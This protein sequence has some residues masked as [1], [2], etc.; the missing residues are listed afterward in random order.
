M[1]QSGVSELSHLD[2]VERSRVRGDPLF[3]FRRNARNTTKAARSVS[4]KPIS[5]RSLPFGLEH[6]LVKASAANQASADK[7]SGQE[8]TE[9]FMDALTTTTIF[10]VGMLVYPF[11]VCGVLAII[12]PE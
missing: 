3:D 9:E 1:M 12:C 6:A 7:V 2:L 5:F 4:N 11:A 10:L 8:H